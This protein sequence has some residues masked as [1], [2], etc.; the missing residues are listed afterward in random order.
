MIRG[1][2]TAVTASAGKLAR[3]SASGRVGETIEDREVFQ[4]YGFQSCPP[5]GAECVILRQGG[6][7]LLVASDDR[8]YRIALEEGEVAVA[9]DDN[10]KMVFKADGTMLIKCAGA[11]NVECDTLNVTA[12][13]KM[14]VNGN[15][16]VT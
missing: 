11:V 5:S 6:M 9:R 7:I 13:T 16:E 1:G 2:V 14:D 10:N 15:L 3:F 8:R 12:A 4:Q